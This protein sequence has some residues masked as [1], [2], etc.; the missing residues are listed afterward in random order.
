M[1]GV[2][3]VCGRRH[4]C[5]RRFLLIES[6]RGRKAELLGI[7]SNEETKYHASNETRK[8]ATYRTKAPFLLSPQTGT[9]VCHCKAGRL[10]ARHTSR[11][12]W[13]TPPRCDMRIRRTVSED[14]RY[15]R[16]RLRVSARVRV[17]VRVR[18]R[19]RS[20]HSLEVQSSRNAL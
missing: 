18:A 13:T 5:P 1:Y 14:A 9:D 15:T 6:Q 20:T 16:V 12:P 19:G 7:R 8:L 11:I 2:A 17:R 4:L 3:Q 10:S